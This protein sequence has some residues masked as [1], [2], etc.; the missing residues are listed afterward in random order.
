MTMNQIEILFKREMK[1]QIFLGNKVCTWRTKIC[2]EPGDTFPV[3]YDGEERVYTL[4][5][6]VPM[7][8]GFVAKYLYTPEGFISEDSM[9][10][11]MRTLTRGHA[12]DV[13]RWGSEHFFEGTA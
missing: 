7:Q 2:G 6:V 1:E 4:L 12:L 11:F 13:Q 8:L 9:L 3:R 5:G 10:R